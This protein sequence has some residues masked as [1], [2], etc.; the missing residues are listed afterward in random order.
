[1]SGIPSHFDGRSMTRILTL[2]LAFLCGLTLLS[3]GLANG[4]E[5][6][7]KAWFEATERGEVL[8]AD[9]LVCE[10][11]KDSFREGAFVLSGIYTFAEEFL[12][13]DQPVEIDASEIEYTRV[14][15]LSSDDRAVV[16][17]KGEVRM[18]A[19]GIV[20]SEELYYQWIMVKEDG[21][22]KW[23]GNTSRIDEPAVAAE[24]TNS[25]NTTIDNTAEN[26]ITNEPEVITPA[27]AI[28]PTDTPEDPSSVLGEQEKDRFAML[29]RLNPPDTRFVL[30]I[31]G[32]NEVEFARIL[33]E[34]HYS[35]EVSFENPEIAWSPESKRLLFT[36]VPVGAENPAL[37]VVGID[38]SEA[39][40]LSLPEE[41][42]FAPTWVEDG[43]R[44]RYLTTQYGYHKFMR[45][46]TADFV[47][48]VD[49][50]GS[51]REVKE[52]PVIEGDYPEVWFF[53]SD[54]K[55][56]LAVVANVEGFS[57][58]GLQFYS[59]DANGENLQK[60]PVDLD[61]FFLDPSK[62]YEVY[63]F[64]MSPD[65]SKIAFGLITY[66]SG[67][68]DN[69][70]TYWEPNEATSLVL[71]LSSGKLTAFPHEDN[72]MF[73]P[74]SW[75]PNGS[76]LVVT[77]DSKSDDDFFDALSEMYLVDYASGEKIALSQPAFG[78]PRLMSDSCVAS[79]DGERFLINGS[80][81]GFYDPS[82]VN[83]LTHEE[84][85]IWLGTASYVIV[86][87]TNDPN[88][89]VVDSLCWITE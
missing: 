80:P 34:G 8:E 19:L 36:E 66:I 9:E 21:Q 38:G 13:T 10:E 20:D 52:L 2:G 17:V 79:P 4:P 26:E 70:G 72:K 28:S 48:Y 33:Y 56:A 47:V 6:A 62:Q 83:M 39:L 44:I 31:G 71:D 57:I 7:A 65:G 60:I 54:E 45:A 68:M 43:T 42:P 12:G 75:A 14:D 41:V 84:K 16:E 89:Y 32:D 73:V 53:S 49:P 15:S 76:Q 51:N 50:D 24:E 30:F 87:D 5:K 11:Q 59:A 64:T 77:S 78:M 61:P 25:T 85:T 82:S 1:M 27:T 63:T 67:I 22:W 37:F 35:Q 3:C 58:R 40:Q 55:T 46:V 86:G 69:G 74:L 23:C 29:M 81:Y 88:D 18:A